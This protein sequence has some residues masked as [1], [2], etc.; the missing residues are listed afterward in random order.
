MALS[1]TF[2]FAGLTVTNGYLRVTEV[3]GS[4]NRVAF[5]VSFAVASDTDA[6][7]Y[8][9]FDFVPNMDGDNFIKQAYEYLKTLPDYA[10][11]TD[12]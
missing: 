6:V 12:V 5:S 10:D 3:S 2:D 11:A 9:R 4:K 1:K 8:E 7:K